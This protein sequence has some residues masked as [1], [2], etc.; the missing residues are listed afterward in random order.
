MDRKEQRLTAHQRKWL[1]RLQACEASGKNFTEYASEQ[2]FPVRELYDAKKVLVNKG[3]LPRTQQKRFQRVQT[4][5]V[6]TDTKWRIQL[7][8][9]VLV[10][11][12]GGVDGGSLST[13]L[14]TVARLG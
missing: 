4:T 12:S 8:N 6:S 1:A 9:G 13:V 7:P 5:T 2:G 14:T 3:V 11:F 10:E